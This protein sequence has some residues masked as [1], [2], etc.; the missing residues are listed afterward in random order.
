MNDCNER[1]RDFD[2]FGARIIEFRVMVGKIWLLGVPGA[3]R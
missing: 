2:N 3:K 1:G